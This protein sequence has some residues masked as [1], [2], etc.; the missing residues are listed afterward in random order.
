MGVAVPVANQL[1]GEDEAG[2]FNSVGELAL[3]LGTRG[4]GDHRRAEHR[5]EQIGHHRLTHAFLV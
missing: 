1:V 4:G 2:T 5:L 3:D